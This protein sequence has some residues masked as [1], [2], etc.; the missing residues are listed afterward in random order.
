MLKPLVGVD[1]GNGVSPSP[2]PPNGAE[3]MDEDEGP[4][5]NMELPGVKGGWSAEDVVGLNASPREGC[6]GTVNRSSRP[7]GFPFPE[8][9]ELLFFVGEGGAGRR[10]EGMLDVGTVPPRPPFGPLAVEL[11]LP[12]ENKTRPA[13]CPMAAGGL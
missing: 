9:F 6:A 7:L 11:E 4:V 12:S 5:G 2:K 13:P 10:R 8:E 1:G 3:P